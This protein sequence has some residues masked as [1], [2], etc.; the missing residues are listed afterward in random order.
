MGPIQSYQRQAE[1]QRRDELVL[2]HL[3]LVK[4]VI[5]RLIGG[6]PKGVDIEGLESAGVVGLVEASAKFDPTRNVQFKTFAYMRIR[7]AIFDELRRNSL[8]P[9][10]MLERVTL[11]RKA[12]RT[13]PAPVTTEAL[14][15]ATGLTVDEVADTLAAERFAKMV[16]WDQAAGSATQGPAVADAPEGEMERWE[17]IQQ[18]AG[19]IEALPE[20]ERTAITLYYREDLRLREIAEIMKLSVSRV[21]RLLSK[22]TFELGE[23][24]RN[25]VADAAEAGC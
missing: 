10:H 9:Q 7:G 4:H 5:G 6:L 22:A 25:K 8:L 1:L 19:A 18:L 13:L 23:A 14:A 3:P 17:T 24:L 11:V 16:S 12:Y 15:A 21:S 2:S 20:R